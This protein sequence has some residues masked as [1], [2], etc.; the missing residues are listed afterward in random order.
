M[1]SCASEPSGQG[2]DD[3]DSD[4]DYSLGLDD[5]SSIDLHSNPMFDDSP[6]SLAAWR[7]EMER[8][9]AIPTGGHGFHNEYQT[10]ATYVDDYED[11]ASDHSS[12]NEEAWCDTRNSY[13]DS[14]DFY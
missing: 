14:L 5:T 3:S 1:L 2:R 9:G 8:V 10:L 6:A 7:T 12:D 11:S 13:Y 4:S